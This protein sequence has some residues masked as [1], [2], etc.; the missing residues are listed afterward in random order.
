M[1]G[2]MTRTRTRTLAVSF[3]LVATVGAACAPKPAPPPPP[4]PSGGGTQNGSLGTC[5]VFPADNPWN[6]DISAAQP[7]TNSTNYINQILADGGDFL[8]ADFGGGGQYGIPYITVPGTQPRIAV[9]FVDWPDE[10]DP[11][12]YPIPLNAP[13]ENGGDRHVLAV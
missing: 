8:H 3:A 6:T 11:G 2:R 13:I 12:P 1:A 7:H 9:N 10:S 5:K 4:P